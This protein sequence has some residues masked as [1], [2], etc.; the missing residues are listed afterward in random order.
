MVIIDPN[1]PLPDHTKLD[2]DECFAKL[3]LET[4]FPEIYKNLIIDDKP[5]LQDRENSIGIE[6][7]NA[8]PQAKRE[9]VKCWY[10]IPYVDEKQAERNIERMAQLGV[11][12]QGGV[13]G[14]PGRSWNPEELDNEHPLQDVIKAIETKVQKL[15]KG[16]YK[17]FTKYELFVLSEASVDVEVIGQFLDVVQSINNKEKQFSVITLQAINDIFRFDLEARTFMKCRIDK[18]QSELANDARKMVEE[19]EV[20]EDDSTRI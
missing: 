4:V 12:Y 7:T 11:E 2:Y 5:D 8:V 13:Q 19:G 14:W 10:M 6:V 18:I 15:N 3:V 17:D 20:N 9:A 1:K 16:H